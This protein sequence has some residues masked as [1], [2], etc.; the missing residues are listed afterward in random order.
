MLSDCLFV[1]CDAVHS[2]FCSRSD[3]ALYKFTFDIDIDILPL[4]VPEYTVCS[5]MWPPY[6]VPILSIDGD[7][8]LDF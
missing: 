8:Y 3:N 5:K 2:Q 1:C 7:F 6:N 4:N